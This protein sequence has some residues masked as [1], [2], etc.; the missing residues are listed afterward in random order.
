MCGGAASSTQRPGLCGGGQ[1]DAVART[2]GTAAS[3]NTRSQLALAS[4]RSHALTIVGGR[5][6][7]EEQY[8]H[9]VFGVSAT[10]APA[11]AAACMLA[12]HSHLDSTL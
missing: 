5:K 1:L 2:V 11:A 10:N 6:E 3:S 12:F 4:R 9:K 7:E 8:A